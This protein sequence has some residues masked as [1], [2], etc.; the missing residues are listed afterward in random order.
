MSTF[1]YCVVGET[2]GRKGKKKSRGNKKGG[3]EKERGN[4]LIILP[5]FP[6]ASS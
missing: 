1:L 6:S 3:K 4:Y 2:L 5:F